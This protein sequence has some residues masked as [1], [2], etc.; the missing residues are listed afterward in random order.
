MTPRDPKRVLRVYGWQGHRGV[1][2]TREIMAARSKAEV[3]RALGLKRP[4]QV[5]NLSETGNADDIA[6]ATTL[7]GVV[8]WRAIDDRDGEW[9]ATQ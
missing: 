5:F 9:Q 8:L 4:A 2:V 1:G 7:P 6:T 3:A